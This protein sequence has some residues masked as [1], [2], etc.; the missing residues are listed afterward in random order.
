MRTNAT[1]KITRPG[2]VSDKTLSELLPYS[3]EAADEFARGIAALE[4]NEREAWKLAQS[5]YIR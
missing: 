1:T 4:V 5:I 2:K 3:K